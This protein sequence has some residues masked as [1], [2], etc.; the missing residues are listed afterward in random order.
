ME[1]KTFK[2]Y[3]DIQKQV[4]PVYLSDS[5]FTESNSKMALFEGNIDFYHSVYSGSNIYY[6][7][8]LIQNGNFENISNNW[9][10]NW[11]R[12]YTTRWNVSADPYS[13]ETDFKAETNYFDISNGIKNTITS[14]SFIVNPAVKYELSM[15]LYSKDGMAINRIGKTINPLRPPVPPSEFYYDYYPEVMY[16]QANYMYYSRIPA[17]YGVEINW[18]DSF[19][20]YIS[21]SLVKSGFGLTSLINQWYAPYYSDGM[22]Q[23]SISTGYSLDIMRVPPEPSW[24]KW[25][26]TTVP[27]QTAAYGK[28]V[29]YA[30]I[31]KIDYFEYS[32]IDN[33]IFKTASMW[34]INKF[35]SFKVDNIVYK[36]ASPQTMLTIVP[37]EGYVNF[38]GSTYLTAT[39]SANNEIEPASTS[40][41]IGDCTGGSNGSFNNTGQFLYMGK[42]IY[43]TSYKTWIPFSP[44]FSTLGGGLSIKSAYISL[45]SVVSSGAIA[46]QPTKLKIAFDKIKNRTAPTNITL[47]NSVQTTSNVS[48]VTVS[49]PR[50]PGQPY[51][52]DITESAKEFFGSTSVVWQ[53]GD[54]CAVLISDGGSYRGNSNLKQISSYENTTFSKP[55][56]IIETTNTRYSAAIQDTHITTS[57]SPGNLVPADTNYNNSAYIYVGKDSSGATRRTL[58]KFDVSSIVSSA[59]ITGATLELYRTT[60]PTN[61][62]DGGLNVYKVL[63]TWDLASA[64][65]NRRTGVASWEAAG[66]QAVNDYDSTSS[67]NVVIPISAGDG[68]KSISLATSLIQGWVTSPDTNNG[69]LLKMLTENG[70]QQTFISADGTSNTPKLTINYTVGGVPQPTKIIQ[71]FGTGGVLPPVPPVIEPPVIL[72]PVKPPSPA[73]DTYTK[74]LLHFD[75]SPIKDETGIGWTPYVGAAIT[76]TSKQFGTGALNLTPK[77]SH[78]ATPYTE[79]WNIGTSDFTF[80]FWLNLSGATTLYNDIADANG[81][82]I[83]WSTR[84]NNLWNIIYFDG[85]KGW[86]SV[87]NL[88]F[89]HRTTEGV[90]AWILSMPSSFRFST[91][92]WYHVAFVR[93]GLYSYIFID[94]VKVTTKVDSVKKNLYTDNTY[95]VYLG[96]IGT[97]IQGTRSYIDEFRYSKGIAR[98]TNNFDPTAALL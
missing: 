24:I 19:G 69:V 17:I 28:V 85:R 46:E 92:K 60:T 41:D 12:N 26:S 1:K 81:I 62:Q 97:T 50:E 58:M 20:S 10:N 45:P 61:T 91:A 93:G 95:Q 96:T 64:T 37:P 53:Q 54:K 56:L 89:G 47:L 74:A 30:F 88:H 22:S 44:S 23:A 55:S 76:T 4:I 67:G 87:W 9:A 82:R 49:Y 33:G 71:S 51:I 80:D 16:E 7:T 35:P 68:V 52:F 29:I 75:S 48:D 3:A 5:I 57:G 98:W 59:L 31:D 78:L 84:K 38:E 70:N 65:W 25:E 8:N 2:V 83:L 39:Y 66:L 15:D 90:N 11:V 43:G 73:P 79:D 63:K 6:G 72:P 42:D 13:S 32:Y 36:Q 14:A 21:K 86:D 94:G 34:Q 18:Y 77:G 40:S 27:P